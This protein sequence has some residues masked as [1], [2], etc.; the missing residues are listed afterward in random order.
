[1]CKIFECTEVNQGKVSR[2]KVIL[3]ISYK[4]GLLTTN[5][6][7]GDFSLR[8]CTIVSQVCYSILE[9]FPISKS[10]LCALCIMFKLSESF[11]KQGFTA[12]TDLQTSVST[13]K[14]SIVQ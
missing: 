14:K 9:N 10:F 7:T 13:Y 1:M 4:L 6:I 2:L 8:I 11:V 12:V 5:P 3:Q